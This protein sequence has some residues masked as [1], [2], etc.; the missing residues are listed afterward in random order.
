MNQLDFEIRMLRQHWISDDGQYDK[1][2]KCSHGKVYVRIGSEVISDEK[3]GS[4][5]TTSSAL[6]LMRTLEQDCK[7]GELSNQLLPCCGHY[8]I[9]KEEGR[10][11]I[12]VIGCPNGIDWSVKHLNGEVILTSEKGTEGKISFEAYRHMVIKYANEVEAF[13]GDPSKKVPDES[14]RKG[15]EQFWAEWRELKVRNFEKK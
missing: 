9:P 8:I 3:S 1:A 6:Y 5:A 14:D 10:N 12:L 4:W 13:Y 11:Q 2:D 15:F 7:P